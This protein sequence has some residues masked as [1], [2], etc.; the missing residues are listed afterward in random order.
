MTKSSSLGGAGA[1]CIGIAMASQRYLLLRMVSHE[2]MRP[3]SHEIKIAERCSA[4]EDDREA[5]L[6]VTPWMQCCCL[7]SNGKHI[8]VELKLHEPA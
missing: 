1:C 8:R 5:S 7:T 4:L 6:N 2:Q 3:L